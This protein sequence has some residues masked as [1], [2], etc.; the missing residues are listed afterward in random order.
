MVRTVIG[1]AL[2][3]TAQA[4]HFGMAGVQTDNFPA[5]LND[6]NLVSPRT[7]PTVEYT[8]HVVDIQSYNECLFVFDGPC[9]SDGSNVFTDPSK[10]NVA[11]MRNNSASGFVLVQ[12]DPTSGYFVQQY[13][14]RNKLSSA[15]N[16]QGHKQVL[17]LLGATNATSDLRVS[18]TGVI[19]EAQLQ[20]DQR[21]KIT[22]PVYVRPVNVSVG[23]APKP[24]LAEA[25]ATAADMN[26]VTLPLAKESNSFP[27]GAFHQV[28]TLEEGDPFYANN[29]CPPTITC[30]Y[31]A[32]HAEAEKVGVVP[33]WENL[34]HRR[35]HSSHDHKR[36]L[37][38]SKRSQKN[39]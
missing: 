35:S 27:G 5:L 36:S 17:A 34:H 39:Q 12:R 29:G 21:K 18:F 22:G 19:D 2:L 38:G 32:G 16:T 9:A 30:L 14:F 20:S 10:L 26:T 33:E 13:R 25:S 28:Q 8:G 23:G 7:W 4:V 37:R 6:P 1:S 11:T 3:L 31:A 24:T 15:G